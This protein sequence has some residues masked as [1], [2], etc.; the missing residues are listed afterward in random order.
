MIF[1]FI[2]IVLLILTGT[3]SFLL[4]K[5]SENPA[6]R[7]PLKIN[8]FT[9][10]NGRGLEVD[11]SILKEA[12]T[13]LGHSV[14]CY[15]YFHNPL[16]V[17]PAD[18]NIFFQVLAAD[19]FPCAPL[20]W[21]IPNPEWYV[22][23]LEE[24]KNV[25]LILCRT[26][27]V[28]RIFTDLKIKTYYLGFT[29]SDCFSGLISKDYKLFT[30]IAGS[31]T[32]KGTDSILSIWKENPQFPLLTILKQDGIGFITHN[33][34]KHGLKV[35][36][37]EL[38]IIRNRCGVHLCPSETEGF[39][40]YIMEAMSTCAVVVTTDAPPMNEFILDKRCLVPYHASSPQRLAMNYYVD[41]V[42]LENTIKSLNKLSTKERRLIGIANR[43]MYMK[44]TAEF[45]ER[46]MNLLNS[47]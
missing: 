46:L 45:N 25:D 42:Q 4:S 40:H 27:E 30:H 43:T 17:S 29:S 36:L 47:P 41:P 22:Q 7:R 8:I 23:S 32:Q 39:G 24:L 19:K 10:F 15:N 37:N 11:Q 9:E 1:K 20:N 13:D 14:N 44:K 26:R 34:H 38:Q 3:A 2:K 16:E 18:I 21:F 12:I 31:S 33:I 5:E 6:I 28:E 35:P